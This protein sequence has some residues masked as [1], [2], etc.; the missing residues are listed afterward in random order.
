MMMMMMVRQMM[1]TSGT[2]PRVVASPRRVGLDQRVFG[3]YL[4]HE[5]GQPRFF[6]VAQ[7][8][9]VQFRNVA[10][11]FHGQT[12]RRLFCFVIINFPHL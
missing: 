8:V 9:R 10:W 6:V 7:R 12:K 1:E 2:K 3:E 5:N 4:F 11:F